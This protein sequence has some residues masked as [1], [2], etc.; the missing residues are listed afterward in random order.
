MSLEVT[1]LACRRA[2]RMVVRGLTFRLQAGEAAQIRGPNGAGKS[3]LLRALAGFLPVEAGDAQ[4]NGLSLTRDCSDFQEQVAYTGHLDAIKLPLTVRENLAHWAPIYGATPDMVEA[5]L[6]HFDLAG[7][8]AEPAALCSAGQRRRL[9]LARLMV[10]DRRLWLLDE[11]TV[12][13]DTASARRLTALIEEHLAGGGL[14]LIATHQDLR[15][16]QATQIELPP[17]QIPRRAGNPDP[18]LEGAWR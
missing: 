6:D 7:L 10:Q 17:D 16:A 12:S 14:A 3:T 13:L 1:D 9:G 15:L 4:L 18:F 5:A 8:A 2:G 11:P